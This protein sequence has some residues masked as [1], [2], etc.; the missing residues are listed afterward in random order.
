LTQKKDVSRRQFLKSATGVAAGAIVFPYYVSAS[1]LGSDGAVAASNRIVMGAIGVGSQGGGDM[2][3]F[4]SKKEVQMVAVCDVDRAHRDRAKER[5]DDRYGNSGKWIYVKR[6][7]LEANPASILDEVI[8]PN[9]TKIYESRDHKQNFLDCVK[10]RA[11]TIA[12]AEIG[13][14][15]ISVALL[16]EIAMLTKSKLR[17]DPDKEVFGNNDKANRLL[18]RPMRS[19]WHL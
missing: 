13:H 14:R 8:G 11:E 18:S 17:W 12:P 19:P 9:E 10:T 3:G 7:K 2:R 6:G 1:A 4:M 5:V 15:S 16:G